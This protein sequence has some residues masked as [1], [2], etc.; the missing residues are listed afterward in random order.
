M[1]LG[2]ISICKRAAMKYPGHCSYTFI[3]ALFVFIICIHNSEL[4]IGQKLDDRVTA[5]IA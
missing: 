3:A 2:G 4:L 1:E 5:P